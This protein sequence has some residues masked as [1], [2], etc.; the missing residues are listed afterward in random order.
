MVF[1]NLVFVGAFS[2]VSKVV[3][4]SSKRS[5]KREVVHLCPGLNFSS[6]M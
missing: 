4:E 1:G 6:Q 5:R 2:T 3:S